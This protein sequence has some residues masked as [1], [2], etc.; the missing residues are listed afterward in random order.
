MSAYTDPR[1]IPFISCCNMKTGSNTLLLSSLSAGVCNR[2][3]APAWPLPSRY[4]RS[5]GCPWPAGSRGYLRSEI[6]ILLFALA[7][8]GLFCRLKALL[9][10]KLPLAAFGLVDG[11]PA[12]GGVAVLVEAGGA[13]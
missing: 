2:G 3:V 10:N 11:D 6:R 1:E 8:Y 9:I 4:R 13:Q 5:A 12:I 7:Q